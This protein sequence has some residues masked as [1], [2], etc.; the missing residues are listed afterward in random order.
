MIVWND[1]FYIILK[2]KYIF[3]HR[4]SMFII[5]GRNTILHTVEGLFITFYQVHWFFSQIQSHIAQN[6]ER[7]GMMMGKVDARDTSQ[8]CSECHFLRIDF[9]EK[10]HTTRVRK[11]FLYRYPVHVHGTKEKV[12]LDADLNAARNIALVPLT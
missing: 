9:Y 3:N 1:S 5:K 10:N 7:K 2:E 4:P 12:Q 11:Q 8:Q 6:A